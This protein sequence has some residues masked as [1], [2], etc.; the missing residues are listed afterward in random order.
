MA[1]K[2]SKAKQKVLKVELTKQ[3][4][5]KDKAIYTNWGRFKKSKAGKVTLVFQQDKKEKKVKANYA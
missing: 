4:K 2:K 1:K 5:S 3:Y